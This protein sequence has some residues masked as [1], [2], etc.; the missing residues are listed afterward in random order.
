M[1][2]FLR[3]SRMEVAFLL[4]VIVR[5]LDKQTVKLFR[6]LLNACMAKIAKDQ[7]V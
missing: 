2:L 7:N 5:V 1:Q 6:R 4:A 3:S